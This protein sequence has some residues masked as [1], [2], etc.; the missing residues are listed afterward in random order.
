LRFSRF[1]RFSRALNTVAGKY[2]FSFLQVCQRSIK[3]GARFLNP[4]INLISSSGLSVPCPSL[5]NSAAVDIHII[6]NPRAFSG[7]FF[8]VL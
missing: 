5:E 4:A 7:L 3:K 8:E 6:G 1:S 2:S